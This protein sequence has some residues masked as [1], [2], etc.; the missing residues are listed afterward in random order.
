MKECKIC[1]KTFVPIVSNQLRCSLCKG[2]Q[3][4]EKVFHKEKCIKCGKEFETYLYNKKFCSSD[5]RNKY[6]YDPV[7]AEKKCSYCGRMF[8]TAK[9]KQLFCS[10][11]CRIA[12][13]KPMNVHV[14]KAS[15]KV[16]LLEDQE[17]IDVPFED[18]PS[19]F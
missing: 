16:K 1:G 5:C 6:H 7:R 18:Q 15:T 11:L 10:D 8:L 13:H 4:K 12:Y 14:D 2:Y 3:K 17:E 9:K 19:Q